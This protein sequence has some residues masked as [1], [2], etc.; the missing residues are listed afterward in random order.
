MVNVTLVND[1]TMAFKSPVRTFF[2]NGVAKA[3]SCQSGKTDERKC[4]LHFAEEI[5]KVD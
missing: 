1:I 4:K 5:G 3:L 2:G